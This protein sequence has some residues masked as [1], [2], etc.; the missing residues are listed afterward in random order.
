MLMNLLKGLR[1]LKD[2]ELV[3]A[4]F[5]NLAGSMGEESFC[6]GTN[7]PMALHVSAATGEAH[8]KSFRKILN[9][10]SALSSQSA[11]GT[12]CSSTVSD[13]MC[14]LFTHYVGRVFGKLMI[15]VHALEIWHTPIDFFKMENPD[16]G[17]FEPPFHPS[18]QHNKFTS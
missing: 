14:R 5:R 11:D 9:A 15:P 10:C 6:I 2:K 7:P 13:L 3:Q 16:F 4:V 8:R 18:T 1:I 12:D 17:N